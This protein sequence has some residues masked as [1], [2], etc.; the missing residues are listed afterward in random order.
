MPAGNFYSG[1]P[2]EKDLL[3]RQTF[4]CVTLRS[5]R[6]GIPKG[7]VQKKLKKNEIIGIKNKDNMKVI[8]SQDKR[9]V[10][11]L[12]SKPEHTLKFFN[13]GK[14]KRSKTRE[15]PVEYIFKPQGIQDYNKAKKVWIT[16]T[17]WHLIILPYEKVL[18]GIVR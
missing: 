6:K 7:I 17:K 4:Y 13:A 16:V 15:V 2:L 5:N 14:K 3:D 8:R 12:S 18:S 10:L 1:I 11:M 9:S